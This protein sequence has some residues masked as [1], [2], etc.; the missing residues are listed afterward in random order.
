MAVTSLFLT[1]IYFPV[2]ISRRSKKGNFAFR[3]YIKKKQNLS[4]MFEGLTGESGT[5]ILPI[6]LLTTILF[7][8]MRVPRENRWRRWSSTG[9]PSLALAPLETRYKMTNGPET[10]KWRKKNKISVFEVTVGLPPTLT[11]CLANT[12]LGQAAM[13]TISVQSELILPQTTAVPM[14]TTWNCPGLTNFFG[15]RLD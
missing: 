6:I 10:G 14:I 2:T 9:T 5:Q 3:I 11:W 8:Q 15:E 7:P 13:V 12:C 4:K 1:W